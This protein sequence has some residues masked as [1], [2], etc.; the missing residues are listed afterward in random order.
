MAKW[1]SSCVAKEGEVGNAVR[2]VA[3]EV[4]KYED[5]GKPSACRGT[6]SRFRDPELELFRPHWKLFAGITVG[7]GIGGVIFWM[8]ARSD[9]AA[10]WADLG[11]TVTVPVFVLG[12]SLVALARSM[13]ESGRFAMEYLNESCRMKWFCCLTLVAVLVGVVGRF[14]CTINWL[15]NVVTVGVC[16]A[17]LGAAIDCLA[18]LAFLVRETIRCS[19]P[20]ESIRVVSKYAARK[21]TWGYLKE[22]YLRLLGIQRR[23]YLERWCAGKA[24]HPP[25]RYYGHYFRSNLDSG[26]GDNDVEVELGRPVSGENAYKDYDLEGLAKL[27]KYLKDNGAELYLSSPEYESEQGVLGILSCKDVMQKEDVR[28]LVFKMG[29]KAVRWRRIVYL[30]EDEDFWDSQESKLNEAIKRAIDKADP[31]QVKAYLDAVNVPLSVLRQVRKSHKVVRDAYGEYV[32]RG[33]HFLRLY[34]RALS[35]IFVMKESDQIYKLAR[36]VRNSVWEETKNIL[37]EMDY[38]TMG[39]YTWLVQQMYTLI[40]DAG[41]KAKN[42]R[43]M[44]GQFG[45]FYESA[46]GWLEDSESKS[47]GDANKMRLVLHEGLTKWLLAAIQKKDG[48][49]IEQLCDA[50]QKIVFG[51]KGIKFD[52]KEVV[53]QH[54]VLAGRLINLAKAKEVNATV[55]KKL[56]CERHSHEPNVNFDDLIGFYRDTSLPFKTLDSYL[57]IFYSPTHVQKNLFTGSS[58]SSGYGMTGGHEMSLAFIFLAGHAIMNCSQPFEPIAG[59]SGKIT[60]ENINEIKKVFKDPFLNHRLDQLEKWIQRCEELQDVAEG[61]EI[62]E[63]KI[64]PAKVKEHESKFWEGYS[65]AVPV[66]SMCLKNGN[67]EIDNNVKNEWRYVLPKIALFDWKYPISG[68][69]GDGYG[70]SIGRKMEKNILNAIIKRGDAKSDVEG[71]MSGAIG[72][73]VKWLEREGCSNDKGFVILAGKHSAE[74]EMSGEKDFVPPWKE[75]VKS[76]GFN[77]FYQ[78]FPI[79]WLQEENE[80]EGEENRAKKKNPQCQRV[81]AVDLRGGIGLRVREEVVAKGIFGKLKIRTWSE[82]EINGAIECGKLDAKDVDKAK[83]N[84]PADVTFFWKYV[85]GELP[86]AKT[87]VGE[88]GDSA[89]VDCA[90]EEG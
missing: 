27:D 7:F 65:R 13:S 1:L 48:E 62:A 61:K 83:G 24:I 89:E 26:V 73:A 53:M 58:S 86:R 20:G 55:V 88:R 57:S 8:I 6:R 64:D 35:E 14:F 81:V 25:S 41:D 22:A 67:Y 40:Q 85:G 80:D 12:I 84:C 18:M 56:F 39:L 71:S 75:E 47:A 52:N 63:A 10:T 50:G 31:I 59:M 54:F 23:D 9:G 82:D 45:G 49:L 72:K 32:E 66:L 37:R 28:G 36:K 70:L 17:S 79:S 74:I 38:H 2:E 68:A 11:L 34:L 15:P 21:L 87:F 46:D 78:G 77:G 19:E 51:R 90:A 30:E 33:Y 5:A 76:R 4:E 44:R 29:S 16:A 43:E 60:K 69:E 3:E 42:L